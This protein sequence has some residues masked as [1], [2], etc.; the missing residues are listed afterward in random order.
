M[1][2]PESTDG[3]TVISKLT[4]VNRLFAVLKSAKFT[5]KIK[6]KATTALGLIC[7]GEHFPHSKEIVKGFLE[8]A[9]EVNKY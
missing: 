3:A 8:M 7:I 4:V 5:S 2:A 1:K 6:E 9:K